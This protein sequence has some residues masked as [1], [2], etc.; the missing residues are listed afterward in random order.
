MWRDIPALAPII[1]TIAAL[2][3]GFVAF[4]STQ[5]YFQRKREPLFYLT[6]S[7]ILYALGVLSTATG[8]WLQAF[9]PG[10]NPE[11]TTYSDPFILIAYCFSAAGNMFLF[12][13]IDDIFLE[14]KKRLLMLVTALNAITIG[15][16]IPQISTE[17]N[18]YL[19]ALNATIFHAVNSLIVGITLAYL[20]FREMKKS[21]EKVA[22]IGFFLIGSFGVLLLMVFASFGVDL[23]LIALKISEGY[24]IFYYLAWLFEALTSLCGYIGYIMPNWFKKLVHVQ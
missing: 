4:R 6:L 2:V 5:K 22:R 19:N 15:L 8:K 18:T 14:R 23:L 17:K 9:L 24:S 1:E 21:Q 13:F 7:L 11:T 20:S 12:A 10:V 3:M 16:M